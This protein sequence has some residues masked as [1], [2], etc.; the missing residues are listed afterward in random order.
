MFNE[1]VGNNSLVLGMLMRKFD[2]FADARQIV[3]NMEDS[4]IVLAKENYGF[5]EIMARLDINRA[6]ND[7]YTAKAVDPAL[8]AMIVQIVIPIVI[9]ILKVAIPLIID[10]MKKDEPT[11]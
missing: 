11:A 9:E 1:K 4:I 7:Y 5:D 8:I 10:S 2:L 6:V 3:K